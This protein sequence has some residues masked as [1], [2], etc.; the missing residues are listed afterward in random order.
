ME[1]IG[2]CNKVSSQ[3]K[4]NLKYELYLYSRIVN[5]T[6][7]VFENVNKTLNKNTFPTAFPKASNLIMDGFAN[8]FRT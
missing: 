4:V 7:E 2:T 3:E 8:L 6:R 1:S 5:S